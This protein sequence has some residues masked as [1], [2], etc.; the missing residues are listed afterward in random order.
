[1]AKVILTQEE[2]R[3]IDT[4]IAA[5]DGNRPDAPSLE[6]WHSISDKLNDAKVGF[7]GEYQ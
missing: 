5:F 2:I 6:I 1:M 3:A 7:D 4:M